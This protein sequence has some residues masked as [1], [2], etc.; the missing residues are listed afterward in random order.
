MKLGARNQGIDDLG[1]VRLG[2]LEPDGKFSFLTRDG[3]QHPVGDDK[4]AV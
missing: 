1:D 2:V 4:P 3:H